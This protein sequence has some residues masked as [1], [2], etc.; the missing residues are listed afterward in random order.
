[1]SSWNK[2]KFSDVVDII[3][4][5]TPKRS[6]D[7]YW[8]GD[9]PWLSVA[10][11]NND[12]RFVNDTS[13]YITELGLD[14]S[15]T[16]ILDKGQ[17]IISARGTV[18][19]LSQLARPMAF[20]QSCYG[21]AAKPDILD[22]NFLYYC[23]KNIIVELK[24]KAHGSV[25]DTITRN[26][27]D[28][29]EILFPDLNEQKKIAEILGAFDDK[30]QLNTQIN[31]TLEQLAQ[32]IFKSWFI[33]FAPTKAKAE[34]KAQG[35]SEAEILQA[36]CDAI[37]GIGVSSAK[38]AEIAKAFPDEVGGNG[39]PCG[40]GDAE[41]STIIQSRREKVKTE[42]ATV[43]SAVSIGELV[44][45]DEYFNKQVYS[46]SIE[47]YLKVY[48][49]D[50]AYNPARVNIGSLGL[51]KENYLGAVS[52]VY[53]VFHTKEHYHWFLERLLKTENIKNQ[54]IS[55]CSGSVRQTLKLAD[56]QTIKCV[57]PSL[58][59]I[60]T[61]NEIWLSF[62]EQINS[63]KRENEILTEIRDGLLPRL[64]NGEVNL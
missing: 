49:W 3:G 36:A 54:I 47:K 27:F 33:D 62:Y 63:L 38:L 28:L 30:I 61:F 45:S 41:L 22:N 42:Q 35:K 34:A 64:L 32:A 23:L 57:I 52:P 9:I 12:Q 19:C 53:E 13:E 18:G 1:M 37:A 25:F 20:N 17:L 51:H 7:E 55:L 56:L 29:I 5:G 60:K 39:V 14:N 40:W 44:R 59:M 24:S 15:S 21:L 11:F 43:L 31:Q 58:E 46:K 8:N 50:F 10:D 48:K 2:A 4:G 26:T 6:K 16:K